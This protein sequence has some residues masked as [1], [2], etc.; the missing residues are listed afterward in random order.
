MCLCA[1]LSLSLPPSSSF[2]CLVGLVVKAS[3]SRAEDRGFESRLHRDFFG[4]ESYQWL[5]IGT[6]VATLPGAWR[7]RVSAGTGWPG[8]SILWLGEMESLICNFCL[9]VAACKIVWADPWDTVACCW[10]VKQPTNKQ[11]NLPLPPSLLIFLSSSLCLSPL[12]PLFLFSVNKSKRFAM[13][14]YSCRYAAANSCSC[15]LH[16]SC[17]YTVTFFFFLIYILFAGNGIQ[18]LFLVGV[19]ACTVVIVE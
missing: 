9:S 13:Y 12:L 18:I 5:K 11:T 15:K 19:V 7:Y 10:D 14:Y 17:P 2:H 3:A 16:N 1:P 6:P 8:V 4:V